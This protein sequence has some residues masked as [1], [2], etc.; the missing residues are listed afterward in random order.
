MGVGSV[1]FQSA[2]QRSEHYIPGVFSRTNYVRGTGGGVSA[3][4]AV[5]VGESKGGEPNKVYWFYST[6]E[7]REV[8]RGGPLLEAVYHAFS[9]GNDLAPQYIGAMRI[10]VGMQSSRILRKSAN[11]LVQIKGYDWGAHANAIKMKLIAGSSQG[12]KLHFLFEG[13][14]VVVDDIS[15]PSF[16]ILYTGSGSAATLVITKTGLTTSVTGGSGTDNLSLEFTS[17]ETIGDLV[18]YIND[19]ANYSCTIVA[20]DPTQL[21]THLDSVAAQNIKTE[22]TAKSDLQAII[23]E[24]NKI[25]LVGSAEFVS[26]AVSREIPD[27]DSDF[28]Y[29]SGG[30]NGTSTVADY[31]DSIDMLENEDIQM[32]GTPSTDKSVHILIRNHCIAMCSVEGRKERMFTVGGALGESVDQA[33]TRAKNLGTKCG[34]L[35]YPGIY[36]YN[37][38]DMSKKKFSSPAMYAAKL[39]GQEAALALNEPST[40]KSVDIL[41]WE[42][43]LKRGDLVQLI[44]AGV[45]AG[46]KSQDN[47]L[48]TIRSLTTHQGDELQ[49]CERSMMRESL[50]MAR[51]LRNAYIGGV[52]KPG[53]DGVGGDAAAIFWTKVNSWYREGLI[54]RAADGSLAWG[55]VIRRIG[56]ATF[57]EYHTYLVAPNNFFFITANQHVYEGS[58]MSVAA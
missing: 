13:N 15:R 58:D 19:Q 32:I 28:V 1:G 20:D 21:T 37:P 27:L 56:S 48:A 23:D 44:K 18:G 10:N 33:I 34:S 52:G 39:I 30:T 50:Y 11:S 22:Y 54:V 25:Y 12:Y 16:K 47:R 8:L 36:T 3:N 53:V 5:F 41:A 4:N 31:S 14:E 45:T 49:C 55:L 29:F 57:I 42:K 43:D 46:G 26:A 17:F 40:N 35:A 38:L 7:S 24:L 6:S 9:P 51:D 2:G